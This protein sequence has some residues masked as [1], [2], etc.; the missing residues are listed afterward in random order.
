[1]DQETLTPTPD[2]TAAEAVVAAIKDLDD[3][4]RMSVL[5]GIVA[6]E[7]VLLSTTGDIVN[8]TRVLA[9]EMSVAL[10]VHN[11]TRDLITEHGQPANAGGGN[12][13]G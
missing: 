10:H 1:M 5:L 13:A 2:Q 7:I 8:L 6:A 9:N 4:T 3:A 12:V 11:V